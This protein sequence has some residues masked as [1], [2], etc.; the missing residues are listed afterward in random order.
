[1]KIVKP[2]YVTTIL[3]LTLVIIIWTTK[4]RY[5]LDYNRMNTNENSRS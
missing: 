3:S 2:E 5:S 4:N 1:M